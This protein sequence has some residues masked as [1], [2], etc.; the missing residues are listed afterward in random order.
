MVITP[1]DSSVEEGDFWTTGKNWLNIG[2]GCR[3][4]VGQGYCKVCL[5]QT[6]AW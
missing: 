1:G 3:L 5:T 6:G 4:S 2:C